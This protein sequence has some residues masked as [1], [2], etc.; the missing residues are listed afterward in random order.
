M[1]EYNVILI[2]YDPTAFIDGKEE[3]EVEAINEQDAFKKAEDLMFNDSRYKYLYEK[4][5]IISD[6]IEIIDR[7]EI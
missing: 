1:K 7:G 6:V 5:Y 2:H 3:I 4:G